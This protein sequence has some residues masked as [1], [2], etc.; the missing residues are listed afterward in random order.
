MSP[1]G[2]KRAIAA[3]KR[4]YEENRRTE[5]AKADR[6]ALVE[7]TAKAQ[8]EQHGFA[9]PLSKFAACLTPDISGE[10][11]AGIIGQVYAA[12]AKAREESKPTPV[13]KLRSRAPIRSLSRRR[14]FPSP[15]P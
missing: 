4:G 10:D 12:E 11:A 8:A 9:L 7:A 5:Q 3:Y 2:I 15:R 1:E 14:A 6:I 13:V